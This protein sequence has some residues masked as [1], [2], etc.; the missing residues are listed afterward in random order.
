MEFPQGRIVNCLIND[1]VTRARELGIEVT[2]PQPDSIERLLLESMDEALAD[3]LGRRTREAVYDYL[4]RNRLIARSE[5]PKRLDDLFKLLNETFGKGATTIGKVIAKRLYAKLG[6]EFVELP[7]Y[8]LTDYVEAAKV[9][10][11][12]ELASKPNSP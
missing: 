11:E 5:I 7:A 1:P 9:R 6:W 12:R 4:E 3:L 10:L 2:R 8:A